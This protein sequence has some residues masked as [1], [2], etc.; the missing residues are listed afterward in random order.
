MKSITIE[1]QRL[2][3]PLSRHW[4]QADLTLLVT[5]LNGRLESLLLN[6]AHHIDDRDSRMYI[7][8]YG[9]WE[10]SKLYG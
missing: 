4:R 10:N 3:S 5:P 6:T 9:D 2:L 8:Y 7:G 1:Y